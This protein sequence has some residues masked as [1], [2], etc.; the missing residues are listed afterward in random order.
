MFTKN[1][2]ENN[3]LTNELSNKLYYY[4][5]IMSYVFLFF[6]YFIIYNI[7]HLPPLFISVVKYTVFKPI[8]VKLPLIIFLPL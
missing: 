8:C 7:F 6:M 3:E 2:Y 1:N 5:T 4:F